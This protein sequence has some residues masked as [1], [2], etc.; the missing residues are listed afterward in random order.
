[1]PHGLDLQ[2]LLL[3][4]T[5]VAQLISAVLWVRVSGASLDP[6]S[7]VAHL[8]REVLEPGTGEEVALGQVEEGAG[9]ADVLPLCSV[10][11]GRLSYWLALPNF[12]IQ[13]NDHTAAC[14]SSSLNHVRVEKDFRVK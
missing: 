5:Q 9:Q 2:L 10:D 1:V 4:S 11:V 14:F 12:P 8:P 3:A 13:N 6:V 7:W